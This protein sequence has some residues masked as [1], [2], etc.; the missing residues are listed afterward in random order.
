MKTKDFIQ[1]QIRLLDSEVDAFTTKL[2]PYERALLRYTVSK[3]FKRFIARGI[4]NLK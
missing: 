3:L 4:T 2:R 1:K